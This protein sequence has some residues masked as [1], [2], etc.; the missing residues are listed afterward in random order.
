MKAKLRIIILLSLFILCLM[1]H[2]F[3][4]NELW[5]EN[6]YSTNIYPKI[7]SILRLCFGF[8]S[9]SVGDLIYG[10]V[11]C[12]LLWSLIKWIASFFQTQENKKSIQENIFRLLRI[13]MILY[14]VFNLCWGINYNRKGI[15]YQTQIA[16]KDYNADELIKINELLVEKVNLTKLKSSGSNLDSISN[17]ELFREAIRAYHN[18]SDSFLF[19]KYDHPSVKSSMWG[20]LGNYLG[21]TGYYNPFTGEA[22]VNTTIPKTT[23]PFIVCHELA[24]Q[25]GYAKESEANFVAYLVCRQSN[26]ESFKYAAYLE[27]FFYA[28]RNLYV[29]DSTSAKRYRNQLNDFVKK[30]I[31]AIVAFNRAHKSKVEPIITWM[32]DLFLKGNQQPQGMLSYEQVTAYLINFYRKFGKI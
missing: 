31:K 18:Q 3:A 19:L 1:I 16:I 5:V 23:Q 30:D 17:D 15:A 12:I 29:F 22:Q 27:L 6:S 9:F 26:N 11:F 24:H 28:N 21:Y 13:I 2:L 14:L 7:A 4:Q 25:L 20:W 32:Y 8:I 10:I